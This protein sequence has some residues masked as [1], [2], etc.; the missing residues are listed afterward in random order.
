MR[1][2]LA[3]VCALLLTG[4]DLYWGGGGEDDVCNTMT[5]TAPSVGLRDPDTGTCE[6]NT[7]G[8]CPCGAYCDVGGGTAA[9]WASCYACEGLGEDTCLA[10]PNCRA[11][12]LDNGD[13]RGYWGCFGTAPSG[14]IEG[15]GCAALGAYDCSRHDDC[16]AV[17]TGT[18]STSTKFETCIAEP[19][20]LC[21]ADTDCGSGQRCDTTTCHQ[22]PCPDC[23][24][25]GACAPTCYGICVPADACTGVDCGSGSHC[26]EQCYPC[27]PTTG[28]TCTSTCEPMCVPDQ[29]CATVDCGPGYTCAEQCDA[30]S[31][32]LVGTCHPVCVPT[33]NDPGQCTGTI[34]CATP[35]P[36]CPTGSTAGIANGCYT[37]YCI[38]N[39]DCSPHD[40]GL[41]YATATCATPPPA[42]PSGTLPGVANGCYT[43]YCIPTSS[44]ELA[45]CET[46]TTEPQCLA[47]GDCAPV[48]AG[49]S[50]TCDPSGCDC[51]ILTYERCESLL[52]PL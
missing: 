43:G 29:T 52:M 17:Y 16:S 31:A 41:C 6:Y 44:C 25:C 30:M 45:A 10:T 22:A 8:T 34:T 38:P 36:A 24:T 37:G 51:Q 9:D 23:P 5:P 4:C 39:A 15:G 42:C 1:T 3:V 2:R 11:A 48:Y 21:L 7:G 33:G 20:A 40:P 26:E 18:T 13:S 28:M 46:L 50:C 32:G 27:D 12:Y 47:R 49:M 35:P 19:N 14:A